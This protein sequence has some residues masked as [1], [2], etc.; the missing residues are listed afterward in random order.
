VGQ[1]VFGADLREQVGLGDQLRRLVAGSAEQKRFACFVDDARENPDEEQR[2]EDHADADGDG[3]VGEDGEGEGGEPDADVEWRAAEDQWDLVPFAH[4]VGD[5]QEDGAEAG[6]RD[7]AGE[8]RGEEQDE[9]RVSGVD[10]AGDGRFCAP[11]RMLVAVRAM[12]PVAGRPPKSGRR[13]WPRPG[14]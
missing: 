6:E 5:D 9:R 14:R 11:E 8:R 1:D 2:G 3:E 12:A 7:E 13:C 10:D 4:V